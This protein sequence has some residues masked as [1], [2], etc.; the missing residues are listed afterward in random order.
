[1]EPWAQNAL[2]PK[3]NPLNEKIV[4]IRKTFQCPVAFLPEDMGLDP[5]RWLRWAAR[6]ISNNP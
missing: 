6:G 3:G 2:E 4:T 5:D 1:M